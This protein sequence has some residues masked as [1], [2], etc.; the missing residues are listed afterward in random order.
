MAMFK[1]VFSATAV[2]AL[3]GAPFLVLWQRQNLYDAWRLHNYQAPAAIVKLADDT[4][5]NTYGRKVFYVE[6]PQLQAL[7]TFRTNCTTGEQTIVL[8]C[9]KSHDGIFVYDVND[10]RLSG[11]QE[12]TSAHEMLHAAYDR[13]SSKEKDRINALTDAAY[14]SLKDD[15]IKKNIDAYRS[16][17]TAIVPNELHSILGTEVKDL[18]KELEDYY[19]R[20]FTDRSKIVAYSVQYESE[21]TNRENAITAYDAQLQGMKTTIDTYNASLEAQGKAIDSEANRLQALLA[22]KDVS[23]YN[24]GIPAYQ[25]MIHKYNQDL[26]TLKTTI[27]SYNNTVEKRNAIV[28]EERSLYKALDTRTPA[29]R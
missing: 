10:S 7:E 26:A 20:Y 8:G 9:Y 4:T 18:P 12:V 22:T 25:Q 24:S 11:V 29:T 19:K 15:R 5:M 23:G 3:T 21:F 6:S 27:T 16:K 14:A 2:I 1:K 13:L 28:G 17:D